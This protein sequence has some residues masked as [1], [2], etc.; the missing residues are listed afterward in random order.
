MRK[1]SACAKFSYYGETKKIT[2]NCKKRALVVY[3]QLKT[4]EIENKNK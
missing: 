2:A 4:A 3:L 1:L